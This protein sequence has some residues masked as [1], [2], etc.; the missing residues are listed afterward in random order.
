MVEGGR[1]MAFAA[2]VASNIALYRA[3][4]SPDEQVAHPAIT[5]PVRA[6]WWAIVPSTWYRPTSTVK[7]FYGKLDLSPP[8]A[9]LAVQ[10]L[11]H[12]GGH[13]DYLDNRPLAVSASSAHHRPLR[14]AGCETIATG[15]YKRLSHQG[16]NLMHWR[17]AG[18]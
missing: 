7:P 2:L 11:P 6:R 10:G 15:A 1:G 13:L 3:P 12:S 4:P 18:K 5:S 9:N 14:L 17:R 8:V 16:C